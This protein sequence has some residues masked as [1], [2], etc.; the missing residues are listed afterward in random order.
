[1]SANCAGCYNKVQS[2]VDNVNHIGAGIITLQETHFTQKGRLNSKFCDFEIFEAIRKKQ[3]GGTLVAA[4]KSLDPILIEEYS[5]DFE[6]ILI[7]VKIG[8]RDIRIMSGYGP[9]ENWTVAERMPFFKALEEE[10][11]K[12]S[13]NEKAIYIQMYAN[14]KLGPTIIKGDPHV[15]SENGKLLAGIIVRNALHVINN[16]KKCIGR[17]TRKRITK[18][19]KEE[20]IIDFVLACEDMAEMIEELVIDEDKQHV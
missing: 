16:S 9:Q 11:I 3:K 19:K 18:K 1:M 17:I 15:Q 6:L 8:G 13:S 20:S 14:S 5:E 7:E 2:L 12:A 10:I 4:H